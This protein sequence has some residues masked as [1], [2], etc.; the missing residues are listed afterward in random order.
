MVVSTLSHTSYGRRP[1]SQ[2]PHNWKRPF[3]VGIIMHDALWLWKFSH[4]IFSPQKISWIFFVVIFSILGSLYTG[5]SRRK[6]KMKHRVIVGRI[7]R[8]DQDFQAVKSP[9]FA[10]YRLLTMGFQ[11]CSLIYQPNKHFR[12]FGIFNEKYFGDW[13]QLCGKTPLCLQRRLSTFM[14]FFEDWWDTIL[15]EVSLLQSR[16]L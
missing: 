2:L 15:I 12:C 5:V 14:E 6:L 8:N 13:S 10:T 11:C 1:Y 4:I 7:W 9:I 3:G 16:K